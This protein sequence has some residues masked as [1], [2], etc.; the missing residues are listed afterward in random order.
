M[1]ASILQMPAFFDS[2]AS[3]GEVDADLAT[4]EE[5]GRA[6]GVAKVD[7]RLR[8]SDIAFARSKA[9]LPKFNVVAGRVLNGAA[10]ETRSVMPMPP[11][12]PASTALAAPTVRPVPPPAVPPAMPKTEGELID[13]VADFNGLITGL[14]T[15]ELAGWMLALNVN[16][17]PMSPR[18]IDRFIKILQRGA[19]QLT[20]EP[21]IVANNGHLSDGQHRLTAIRRTGIAAECDIRFGIARE[22]FSVTGTGA[23]AQRATPWPSRASPTPPCRP[24]S[25]G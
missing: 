10:S 24:P 25:A 12:R 8:I 1:S 6:N 16:N 3:Y 17:R 2:L 13:L 4:I 23:G 14:V 19:W 9:G 20:G 5:W 15:P 7:G 22:A 21:I 18:A 11:T